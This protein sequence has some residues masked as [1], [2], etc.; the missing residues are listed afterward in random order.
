MTADLVPTAIIAVRFSHDAVNVI[1]SMTQTP[2]VKVSQAS[3]SVGERVERCGAIFGITPRTCK[4]I[5]KIGAPKQGIKTAFTKS[6]NQTAT[7]LSE[8]LAAGRR[9]GGQFSGV[10]GKLR[11]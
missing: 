9:V 7:N 8:L 2:I 6:R 5:N 10:P 1:Q 3:R 11:K 4:T